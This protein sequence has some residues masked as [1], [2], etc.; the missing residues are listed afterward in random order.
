MDKKIGP[1]AWRG[2]EPEALNGYLYYR[3]N[4]R[5]MQVKKYECK[6]CHGLC[7]PGELEGD[8]CFECRGAGDT[9]AEHTRN[10]PANDPKEDARNL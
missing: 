10:E 3:E 7:D 9:T 2:T 1:N 6:I 4:G 8:V 5:E